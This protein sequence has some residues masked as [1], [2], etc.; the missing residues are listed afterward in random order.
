LEHDQVPLLTT[1][2]VFFRGLVEELLWFI[3]GST[4]SKVLEAKGINIWKGNTTRE[5]LDARGLDYEEGSIGAGYGFQW[6]HCGAEYRGINHDYTGQGVDQVSELIEGL[7]KDP[8]SRRH[9][10]C[11]WNPAALK[12]MA[13]PPCHV[14]YQVYVKDGTLHAAMYQ[15]SADIGLGVPFNIASYAILTR[16]IAHC[17][18]LKPGTFM[19]ITGDTHIYVNHIDALKEQLKRVPRKAPTMHINTK[20]RD[21]FELKYS[22]FIL[23]GYEPHDSIRMDMVI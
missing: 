8:N 23:E 14:L 11:S 19:H 1:K 5:F 3:S 16:I 18:D 22:D 15:R 10:I 9:I 12:K 17:C 6:R 7:R 4:D 21:I 20:S 13:L 2:K